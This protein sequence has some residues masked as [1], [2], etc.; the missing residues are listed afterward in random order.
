[1]GE[2]L[3][4]SIFDIEDADGLRRATV[5][6]QWI[7]SDGTTDTDIQ[8]ATSSS[9]T[10]AGADLGKAISVRVSFTDGQGHEETLTSAPTGPVVG[11]GPPETPR[12]FTV[13]PGDQELVVSWEPPEDNGNAPARAY[14]VQWKKDGQE[15][16]EDQRQEAR[17]SPYTITHLANGIRYTVRV[18]TR[19]NNGYGPSTEEVS[20]TPTSGSAT[21]LDTPVLSE[22]E[23]L[24]HN[25]VRLDWEDIEGTDSYEVQFFQSG[26]W[27]ELPAVGVGV[28]FDG[29]S[30]VVSELPEGRMSWLKVRAVSATGESEWSEIALIFPTNASDW[31]P[32]GENNPATGKPTI[33]GTAQV[34]E[35]L[36]ADTSGIADVDGLDDAIFSYQWLADD[37]VVQGATGSSYTL[38]DGDTG[39]AIKVRVSFTDGAGNEESLTSPATEAVAAATQS[40]NPATGRPTISGTAQLGETLTA[41]TSG[42]ADPDGLDNAVFSYQWLDDDTAVQG[43]TGSSYTL[44]DDNEGNAIKV[45]VSFTDDAG[46]EESLTSPATAAVREP[47]TVSMENEPSSHDGENVFTFELRFSEEVNLSFRTLKDHAFTVDGGEV[48]KAKRIEKGS[49]IRW[50]ITVMPDGDGQVTITLPVTEDCTDDGAICTEDGRMLSNRLVLTVSGPGL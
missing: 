40:N 37:T 27:V 5:R 28:E 8:G 25:M 22:P 44:S 31:G 13:T 34:G 10:L 14:L 49:N 33:S 20:G 23:I 16:S 48:K 29:S 3:T 1:M 32:E 46:N 39:K 50:R 43:A 41:D 38:A 36:T 19:N 12:N 35:A 24:H 15:Y 11:D 42:I 47:L 2:T 45:I 6:Y 17:E 26:D 4:A 18:T 30:A 9:Y 7:S 21:S